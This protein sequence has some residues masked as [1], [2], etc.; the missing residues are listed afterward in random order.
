MINTCHIRGFNQTHCTSF[1]D[2]KHVLI[3]ISMQLFQLFMIRI[4]VKLYIIQNIY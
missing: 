1:H 2:Q 3:H 4:F